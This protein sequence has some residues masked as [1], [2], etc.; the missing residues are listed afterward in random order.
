MLHAMLTALVN[1]SRIMG[2]RNDVI[3]VC[4]RRAL[5][6]ALIVGLAAIFASSSTR[7]QN[8]FVKACKVG[9][10]VSALE[11]DGNAIACRALAIQAKAQSYQIGCNGAERKDAVMLTA[12]ISINEKSPRLTSSSLVANMENSKRAPE[13][14]AACA[15]VW[16][17]R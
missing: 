4:S 13:E 17:S 5:R 2:N 11:A 3:S 7:A 16:G 6:T 12:P 14:V 9:D 8:A 15:K 10:E 1:R